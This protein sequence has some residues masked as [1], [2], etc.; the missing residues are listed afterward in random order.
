MESDEFRGG[1]YLC[2]G[3]DV[4]LTKEPNIF[5]AMSLVHSRVRRVIFGVSDEGMG[6]LGGTNASIHSLP[7]TNHH[8]RAFR[9]NLSDGSD[10]CSQETMARK[11]LVAQLYTIHKEKG[12]EC[13]DIIHPK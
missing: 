2:T 4:Y 6:G 8:Y 3:F 13:V 11:S 5:E 7:G 9:L 12:V 1:Q 10:G